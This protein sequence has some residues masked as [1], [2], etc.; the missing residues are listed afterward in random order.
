MVQD[1]SLF[2]ILKDYTIGVWKEQISIILEKHGLMQMIVHPDYT[3]DKEARRVYADLLCYLSELR[4]QGETWIALPSEVAAWWRLR[5]R[6]SLV[7][8]GRSWHIEGNGKDRAR[9]AYAT[10]T[11]GKLVYELEPTSEGTMCH[12]PS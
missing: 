12:A 6:L 5:Q 3:I 4:A 7:S 11:D 10:I 1:Y 9:I 8:D 2:H